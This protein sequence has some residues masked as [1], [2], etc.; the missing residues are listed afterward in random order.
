LP[1]GV[2]RIPPLETMGP[3]IREAMLSTGI[4]QQE[5]ASRTGVTSRFIRYLLRNQRTP[6]LLTALAIGQVLG[7]TVPM[8]PAPPHLETPKERRRREWEEHRQ[9]E[10]RAAV[11][12]LVT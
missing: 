9:A 7:I 12:N 2:R 10:Q 3:A 11:A 8:P 4:R 1:R 5:L 6:R